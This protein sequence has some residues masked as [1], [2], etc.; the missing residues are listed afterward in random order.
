MPSSWETSGSPCPPPAALLTF[1]A[2]ESVEDDAVLAAPF[3]YRTPDR[4]RWA[5]QVRGRVLAVNRPDGK[6]GTHKTV[7]GDE[8][9]IVLSTDGIRVRRNF[10][11]WLLPYSKPSTAPQ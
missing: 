8:Y 3:P 1:Q 2:L 5:L 11:E 7:P 6:S 10:R 9:T 4:D